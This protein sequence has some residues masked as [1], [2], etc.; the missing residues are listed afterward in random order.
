MSKK[1]GTGKCKFVTKMK[2]AEK[3]DEVAESNKN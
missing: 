2:A 3:V 1:S